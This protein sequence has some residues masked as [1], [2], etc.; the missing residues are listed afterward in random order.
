MM[1]KLA[2]ALLAAAMTVSVGTVAFAA[3]PDV[4]D[5]QDALDKYMTLFDGDIEII[6]DKVYLDGGIDYGTITPDLVI[7]LDV[8][9]ITF[10]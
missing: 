10:N 4:K 9:G 8:S 3:G 5:V 7:T 1:K 6:D 2:A